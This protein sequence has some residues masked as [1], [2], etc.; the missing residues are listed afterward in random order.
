MAKIAKQ[1]LKGPQLSAAPQGNHPGLVRLVELL[2]VQAARA[3]MRAEFT[4]EAA[5][6]NDSPIH[7]NFHEK[8]DE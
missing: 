3:A 6:Q 5:E 2:A 1:A 8:K 7:C 4:A